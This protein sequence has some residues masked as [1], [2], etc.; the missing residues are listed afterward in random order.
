MCATV[1]AEEGLAHRAV[2]VAEVLLREA[3]ARQSPEERAQ[4]RKIARMIAD[5]HG[6]ELTVAL[7]DQAFR[8]HRPERIANQLAYL[9]DPEGVVVAGPLA[10]KEDILYAEIDPGRAGRRAGDT[11]DGGGRWW[12]A[13]EAKRGAEACGG[14][15]E[16]S[17]GA[18]QRRALSRAVRVLELGRCGESQKP[19]G[20]RR[21]APQEVARCRQRPALES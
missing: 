8:S 12:R 2:D 17:E 14:T 7:A 20:G 9:L 1:D 3:R 16:G 18:A 4:A 6:K 10:Q 21:P 5:P 13:G 19:A 15:G 11:G